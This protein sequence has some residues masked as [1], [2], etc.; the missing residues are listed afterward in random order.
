[1][2]RLSACLISYN[3]EL[4]LPRALTFLAGIAHEIW[5]VD[6]VRT[7][8]FRRPVGGPGGPPHNFSG[9]SSKRSE[10]AWQ[11]VFLIVC[12]QAG[13]E[14]IHRT[15]YNFG[16]GASI[17][18]SQS[19]ESSETTLGRS[20]GKLLRLEIHANQASADA[21]LGAVLQHSRAHAFFV[22]ESAVGRIH[23]L[24]IDVRFS[25]FQQP[26]LPRYFRIA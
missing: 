14:T 25:H 16:I 6:S 19:E 8:N 15:P 11:V 24:K 10:C 4:N 2:N 7:C 9:D 13:G 1:M 26:V 17:S 22:E 12:N 23:V 20:A 3:E 5:G 21:K 18:Q